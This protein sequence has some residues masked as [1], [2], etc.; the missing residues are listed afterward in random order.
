MYVVEVSQCENTTDLLLQMVKLNVRSG[1]D[2]S[3]RNT[4]VPKNNN[5]IKFP[6]QVQCPYLSTLTIF[7]M[8][9]LYAVMRKTLDTL[10]SVTV[11]FPRTTTANGVPDTVRRPHQGVL[12]SQNA[13][14]LRYNCKCK[15]LMLICMAFPIETF[16]KLIP[17]NTIMYRD[18][19]EYQI[20]LN[21][22][23]T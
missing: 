23:K 17:I 12:Y 9:M 8:P 18:S 13:I 3:E 11:L 6:F 19:K 14:V 5:C 16:K 1:H 22:S 2:K 4:E 20:L 7:Q 15:S 10:P 21:L